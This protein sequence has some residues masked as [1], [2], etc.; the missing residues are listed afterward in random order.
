[1]K[2]KFDQNQDYQL[3]AIRAVVD[4]FDGQ[5]LAQGEQEISFQT[6]GQ[7]L[8][9]LG[10]ANH[11]LLSEDA[12]LKNVNAVQE[13]NELAPVDELAGHNFSVEMETGTGKTYVYLR[14][15]FELQ[16]RYGW[17]KF[18]IVVPS[19]AIR[20]GVLQTIELTRDHFAALYGNVPLDA[21]VY[22]SSQVSRLR[23]FATSNQMQL[24][25]INIQA[26]DKKDIAVIHRD[27]D[28]LSGYRPIEFIQ[29][30]NPIVVIDEPQNMESENA[31]AALES[32]HPACTLRY[33]AT[34]KNSYNL[35]Y[36]LDP[37]KAYDLRLVKRIEV[38][39][40]LEQPGFN[41]PYIKVLSITATKTKITAKLEIDLETAKGPARK[42]VSI[43][44]NGDD[45]YQ[46]SGQR[47]Q[48]S[49]YVVS[50][51]DAGVGAISFNNG[52]TLEVG[53]T[54]GGYT[55]D[56]MRIQIEETVK[57]HFEKELKIARLPEEQR[58]KVLSLFFIDRVANYAPAEGKLRAW[59]SE[60]Y[61]RLAASTRYRVLDPPPVD[62]VHD[63]YFAE[64]RNGAKDSNGATKADDE[65]YHKIMRAKQ[66]LLSREE[67][68]RFIFSH[69]ALREGWDN[70]NVFQICT[71]NETR[72]VVRKRQEIGRGLR[73]PVRANGERSFDADINRLTVIANES[74]HQFADTLQKEMQDEWGVSFKDRIVNQRDRRTASLKQGWMLDED[75]EA[76]WERIKHKTRYRVQ[77]DT[78]E[79]IEKAVENF[80]FWPVNKPDFEVLK[81]ELITTEEGVETKLRSTQRHE[82]R[83][84]TFKTPDLLN[85]LQ[86]ETELTRSTLAE[87]LIRSERLDEV[88]LNP[89]QFLDGVLRATQKART[90]L[91]IGGIK[92][93]RIAGQCW[94]MMFFETKELES[95][96][97][98]MLIVNKSI[99][100]SVVYDS[101]VESKFA[102]ELDARED[103]K[104]FI[105]LPA[106]FKIE[107]PLGTYNPDW[108]I[109]Q[110][111]VGEEEKLYLVRETKGADN[112]MGIS[113][114]ERKKILCGVGH[115]KALGVNFGWAKESTDINDLNYQLTDK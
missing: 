25:I 73:L 108:A 45:L 98:K 93:E 7:L 92:Y 78:E 67:P 54:Q 15:L 74:Y 76:L 4:V 18:I 17:K 43:S 69:S 21:W 51:I 104:L 59:F 101:A 22:D 96:T 57:E 65:A 85:F 114:P 13:R 86:R 66:V 71:L 82:A 56:I 88:Q 97:S 29:A 36:R 106:W 53:Q 32:L 70:P 72:S 26:F 64:D 49:G 105:K 48:Y 39:S 107:T 35:L 80:K 30:A 81:G 5:P 87:I 100:D 31:K 2:I 84:L 89:Q 9:E 111:K 75:F 33:S 79:L 94:D 58:L 46:A 113:E 60:I 90:D 110:Q 109:V 8:T 61:G 68:L 38:A 16:A 99:Y 6:P 1:M 55:D 63:G 50:G 44:K 41:N 112:F 40:V 62:K 83:Q 115:F 12:L 23:S 20:E 14:T 47:E 77:Y 42:T 103:I 91:L 24:L 37:V 95:Y 19:V 28:K 27:N 102:E 3:D 34:H 52:V 10:I 11:S